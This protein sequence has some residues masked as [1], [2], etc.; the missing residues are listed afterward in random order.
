[1]LTDSLCQFPGKLCRQVIIAAQC[2]KPFIGN[3]SFNQSCRGKLCGHQFNGPVLN[4]ADIE[5]KYTSMRGA[6]WLMRQL[7]RDDWRKV[8]RL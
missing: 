5:K 7:R 6:Y 3:V 8:N 4:R 1:M 2:C